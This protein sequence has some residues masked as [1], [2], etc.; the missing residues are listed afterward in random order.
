MPR[1]C[2]R[3]WRRVLPDYMVPAAFVVLDRLPLTA[4]RQA[5]PRGAAG[6]GV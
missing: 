5:R 1:R 3:M 2:G 6:A 4:E